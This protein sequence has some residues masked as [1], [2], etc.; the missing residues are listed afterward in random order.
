M[1][2]E[3]VYMKADYEPWWMF[4]DWEKMIQ[5]RKAFSTAKDAHNYLHD[6]KKEFGEKYTHYEERKNCFFAYW[7]ES[8]RFFCE[9]C[10]DDMQ[11]FHGIITLTDGKPASLTLINNSNI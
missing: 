5:Y 11:I 8:E 4:E 7:T 10:D 9:G 1:V 3:I 2:Y 6:L